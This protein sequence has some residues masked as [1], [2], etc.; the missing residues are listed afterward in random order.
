MEPILIYFH[1]HERYQPSFSSM[2][3]CIVHLTVFYSVSMYCMA[4]NKCN[5]K[6]KQFISDVS[7]VSLS[8]SRCDFSLFAE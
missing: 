3:V 2:I 1:E 8:F 7:Y 4:F 6:C 5:A